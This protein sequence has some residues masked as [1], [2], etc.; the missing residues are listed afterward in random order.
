[1]GRG[2]RGVRLRMRFTLKAVGA[3]CATRLREMQAEV[4]NPGARWANVR[5]AHR[6][7]YRELAAE[8]LLDGRRAA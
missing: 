2:F 1:M 3:L 7:L 6:A 8:G 5:E 4:L